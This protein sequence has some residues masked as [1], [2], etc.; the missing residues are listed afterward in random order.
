MFKVV[1]GWSFQPLYLKFLI[2]QFPGKYFQIEVYD[3]WLK[4]MHI[5]TPSCIISPCGS[6]IKIADWMGPPHRQMIDQVT[7]N[8]SEIEG[9]LRATILTLLTISCKCMVRKEIQIHCILSQRGQISSQAIAIIVILGARF[10][11]LVI[12]CN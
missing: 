7:K 3:S 2:K 5:T 8:L 1:K 4:N 10:A 9:R 12:L 11:L 6:L